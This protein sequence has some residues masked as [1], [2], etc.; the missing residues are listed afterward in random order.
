MENN[1]NHK[2]VNIQLDGVI[3]KGDLVIPKNAIG[4]VIFSHG[5]G[6]SRLSP[7]NNFVAEVLQKNDLATLL[8]D[9]L[10]EDEDSIYKNRFDIDLLTLRLIDVTQW[11]QQ[12]KETKKLSIGYFGASTGAASALRAAAFYEELIKAV[13]SRGGRPDL[14]INDISKVTAATLLIVGGNDDVVIELNEKAYQ[15]LHCQRKL[16]II[17]KASHLFE[18]PGKL[19][20]VAQIS[21]NWFATYLKS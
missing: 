1:F 16:E 7:R 8:F 4:L 14:A 3:L 11:V 13:V 17:P 9:L 10:T 6:S 21:A 20:E 15:K 2:A 5:S 12:L 19:N 18:E